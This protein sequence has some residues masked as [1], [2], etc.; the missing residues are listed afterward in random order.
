MVIPI[1]ADIDLFKARRAG[2]EMARQ[3]GFQDG[4]VPLIELAIAELV[5]N[6]LKHAGQGIL[7]I[8]P[9]DNGM[10]IISEDNGSGMEDIAAVLSGAKK[11]RKGLGIG[12]AGVN[13]MMDQLEI[14]SE[15]G[16][17]TTVITRKWLL[18][19]PL[20]QRRQQDDAVCST[21]LMQYGI[22]SIPAYGAEVNG[23]AYLI[24]EYEGQALLAVI[25]GLGHGERAAEAALAAVDYLRTNYRQDLAAIIA[26]CHHA[27]KKTR[28]VVMGLARV[29][30]A[31]ATLTCSGVGN[32]RIKTN[33]V[34]PARP[35]S[36]PGIVGGNFRHAMQEV[37]PYSKGDTLF[38][39]SDGISER[40]DPVRFDAQGRGRGPQQIAEDVVREFGKNNDDTT[41][42]VAR[43]E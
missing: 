39:Y 38:L 40:L 5:T 7:T 4:D 21:G 20:S 13:R 11:S 36:V 22:C 31:A 17:G 9:V 42:I 43:E 3:I 19:P 18:R 33:G 41:I 14:H 1:S 27:L 35:V 16:R 32:I 34:Q 2:R 10:E 23:D 24:R 28:G 26:G 8:T 37:F 12:L 30:F 15:K 25:D 6:I 29:N